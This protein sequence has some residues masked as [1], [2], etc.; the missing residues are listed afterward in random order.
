MSL[1]YPHEKKPPKPHGVP[2]NPWGLKPENPQKF[3]WGFKPQISVMG[4][5]TPYFIFK[6]VEVTVSVY[7]YN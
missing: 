5:K 3:K 7:M 4:L 1:K 6:R 2:K